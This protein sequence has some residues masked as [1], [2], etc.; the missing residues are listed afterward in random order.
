MSKKKN[1][2]NDLEEFLRLQA[3]SLV[4]P[5]SLS[6]KVNDTPLKTESVQHPFPVSPMASATQ[7][8]LSEKELIKAVHLLAANKKAFYQFITTVVETL[9]NKSTE[10]VLLINTALYLKG[11]SNWKEVVRDYWKEKAH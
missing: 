2:L 9:P 1:T 4:T 11:G 10:D 3:S 7:E 8:L 5:A 6:E